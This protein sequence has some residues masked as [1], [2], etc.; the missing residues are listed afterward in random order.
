MI[1]YLPNGV[2]LLSDRTGS[3]A[4]IMP[5]CLSLLSL[6]P[7]QVQLLLADIAQVMSF[8]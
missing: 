2:S 3:A 8:V 1:S 7:P 5:V 4:P 6:A